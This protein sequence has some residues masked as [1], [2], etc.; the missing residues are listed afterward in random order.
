MPIEKQIA[1][2]M[3]TRLDTI[4]SRVETL[5]KEGKLQ[6][7]T[8]GEL[9]KH[10]DTFADNLQIAAYGK[11]AFEAFRAKVAKVI[12]KDP[13]EKY[14]DTFDNPIKPIQTDPDE[15]YMHKMEA[16]F[17]GKAQETFDKDRSSTVVERDEYN[18]RDLNEYAGG[19]KKQPSWSKGPAG[20]STIQ[21]ATKPQP[22][23]A[24]P[25]KSDKTWAD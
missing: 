3:L 6:P 18:V 16:P 22:R 21:G 7:R 15:G 14:M 2:K 11:E 24:S 10:I 20:K 23:Q 13:D 8:A 17:N 25:A 1:S 9:L 4:A 5:T 12:Q 19:T